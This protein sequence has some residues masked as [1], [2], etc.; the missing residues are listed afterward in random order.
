MGSGSSRSTRL[1]LAALIWTVVGIGLLIAGSR[2]AGGW[3]IILAG[4]ALG[5]LKGR[6]LLAGM[7]RANAARI[8]SGPDRASI[9]AAYSLSSWG[10]GGFFMVLGMVLRHSGLPPR[11]L[12]FIYVSAGF[13]LWLASCSVWRAWHRFTS[14]VTDP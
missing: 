8:V 2:M 7:A 6:F 5:F 1:V 13:A 12:G 10:I 14:R 11:L 9:L 4:F 3:A